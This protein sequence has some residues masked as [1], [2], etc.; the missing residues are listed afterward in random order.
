MNLLRYAGRSL[1][2]IGCGWLPRLVYDLRDQKVGRDAVESKS[3][4]V[5]QFSLPVC[6][7]SSP[8]FKQQTSVKIWSIGFRI[9]RSLSLGGNFYNFHHRV[10]RRSDSQSVHVVE[11]TTRI[12]KVE[13][14]RFFLDFEENTCKLSQPVVGLAHKS[15]CLF[16]LKNLCFKMR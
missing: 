12:H 1:W 10:A 9:S 13:S 14:S 7:I 2:F 6:S 3:Y 11:S 8:F 15:G 5:L 4:H 16:M